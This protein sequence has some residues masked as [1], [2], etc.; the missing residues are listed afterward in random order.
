MD[1][2]TQQQQPALEF[3]IKLLICDVCSLHWINHSMYC[4][5]DWQSEPLSREQKPK[6]IN[7]FHNVYQSERKRSL[8]WATAAQNRRRNFSNKQKPNSLCIRGRVASKSVKLMSWRRWYVFSGSM[9][10][11]LACLS[12][13]RVAFV[14]SCDSFF[15]CR[16]FEYL[17]CFIILFTVLYNFV[18]AGNEYVV[19]THAYTRST[20]F[21]HIQTIHSPLFHSLFYTLRR[22]TER[23][24]LIMKSKFLENAFSC[25]S[26][27]S[28]L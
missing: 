26:G 13:R 10:E 25:I 21:C 7:F 16:F 3:Q 8:K 27:P 18:S 17:C 19:S 14:C 22:R 24:S 12:V 1:P 5:I 23:A 20:Y 4:E 15:R 2:L 28:L 9:K 11:W 6:K